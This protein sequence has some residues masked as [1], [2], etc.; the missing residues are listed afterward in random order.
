MLDQIF[1]CISNKLKGEALGVLWI[2]A[3]IGYLIDSFAKV[4]I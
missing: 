1:H 4:I 3:S 2:K